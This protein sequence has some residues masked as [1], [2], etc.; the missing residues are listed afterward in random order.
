[1]QSGVP[2]CSYSLN[3]AVGW[4]LFCGKFLPTHAAQPS[5]FISHA[6]W[7]PFALSIL[8]YFDRLIRLSGRDL[9]L[10]GINQFRVCMRQAW[11]RKINRHWISVL[12]STRVGYIQKWRRNILLSHQANICVERPD[13]TCRSRPV[14]RETCDRGKREQVRLAWFRIA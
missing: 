11:A 9:V 6:K 1:M 5:E 2:P 7:K 13:V 10:L 8:S 3:G 14:L 12:C 4:G